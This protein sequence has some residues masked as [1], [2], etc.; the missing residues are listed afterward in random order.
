MTSSVFP[1]TKSF[2]HTSCGCCIQRQVPYN[3]NTD[4]APMDSNIFSP[5]PKTRVFFQGLGWALEQAGL[6]QIQQSWK[7]HSQLSTC[8]MW[9]FPKIA[10]TP[11]IIHLNGT[12][13]YFHHPFWGILQFL[14]QHPCLF[15]QNL[16]P[17]PRKSTCGMRSCGNCTLRHCFS[18]WALITWEKKN[19]GQLFR[20]VQEVPAYR[21]PPKK[22]QNKQTCRNYYLDLQVGVPIKPL[23]DGELTD[24]RN[25]LAPLWRCWYV[26]LKNDLKSCFCESCVWFRSSTIYLYSWFS[27]P[28]TCKFIN[29]R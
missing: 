9:M 4:E 7:G 23:K 19:A 17:F 24:C 15:F 2:H 21:P 28:R 22:K 5:L 25:H 1:K 6:I 26:F 10:G 20:D 14:V 11:Q 13:H 8:P 27:T 16:H 18:V 29:Y 12:F 3:K